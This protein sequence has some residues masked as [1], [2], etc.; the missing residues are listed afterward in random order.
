MD[1]MINILQTNSLAK[2]SCSKSAHAV[3]TMGF[4]NNEIETFF[5]AE[6]RTQKKICHFCKVI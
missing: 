6:K 4:A 1:C 2:G 3:K 5:A